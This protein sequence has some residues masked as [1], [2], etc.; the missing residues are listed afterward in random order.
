MSL[1][2]LTV[3]RGDRAIVSFHSVFPGNRAIYPGCQLKS[4]LEPGIPGVIMLPS[5]Y[6]FITNLHPNA[7]SVNS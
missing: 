7:A 6:T 1:K 3:R 4:T 2:L 5:G